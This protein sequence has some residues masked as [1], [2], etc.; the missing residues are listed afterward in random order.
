MVKKKINRVSCETQKLH[1]IH[2]SVSTNKVLSKYTHA[3]SFIYRY[4]LEILW[5][6]F[7]NTARKQVK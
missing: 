5:V 2:I 3:R 7:Q 6:R 4:T 1:E